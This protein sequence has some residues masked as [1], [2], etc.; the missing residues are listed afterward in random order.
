MAKIPIKEFCRTAMDDYF[1]RLKEEVTTLDPERIPNTN[2]PAGWRDLRLAQLESDE[3]W[4]R[5]DL[6]K[7]L[8][9]G[10]LTPKGYLA[11]QSR[12]EALYQEFKNETQ[13]LYEKAIKIQDPR[14]T[15][16]H[17]IP[18]GRKGPLIK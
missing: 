1:K 17:Q 11:A 15:P 13:K 7:A 6:E 16:E 2:S 4:T 14:D 10:H 3:Q 9:E 12:C 18:K 5:H 8:G